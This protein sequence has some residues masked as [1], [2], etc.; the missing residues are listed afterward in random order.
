MSK[1]IF[2][3]G[4][5]FTWGEG[6]YFY[7]D[8][9]NLPFNHEHTFDFNSITEGMAAYKNK[10]RWLNLVCSEL[11]TWSVSK[12]LN[13]SMNGLNIRFL[14]ELLENNGFLDLRKGT[15]V[16]NDIW[17]NYQFNINLSD[18]DTLIFQFS[19]ISRDEESITSLLEE[20]DILLTKVENEYNIKVYTF[21]WM[22][23]NYE[24]PIYQTK[25]MHRHVPIYFNNDK[26]NYFEPL[27]NEDSFNLTIKSDF[28]QKNLQINDMHFNHNGNRV[29]A[30]SIIKK[31]KEDK[32]E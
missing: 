30:N 11:D 29:I 31:I 22:V 2:A 7:S 19:S 13:G 14:S 26:Y 12:L 20:L 21:V 25:Y 24:N 16:N 5:S 3:L 18:F 15:F 27:V 1:G 32:N 4:D 6:L 8:L 10:Y 17:K 9:D 23:E 28:A